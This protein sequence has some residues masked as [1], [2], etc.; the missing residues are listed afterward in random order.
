[1]LVTTEMPMPAAGTCGAGRAGAPPESLSLL[2]W[3]EEPHLGEWRVRPRPRQFFQAEDGIRDVAV[4][5]VQTCALPISNIPGR[6]GR[7]F[8]IRH[9]GNWL[10]GIAAGP[11]GSQ[12][13]QEQVKLLLPCTG[14]YT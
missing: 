5:G 3:F 1:M 12:D 8:S 11:R 13:P 10:S 6:S 14:L 7:S 2:A 4:T 9:N